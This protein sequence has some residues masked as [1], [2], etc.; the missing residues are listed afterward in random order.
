M[1]TSAGR[2]ESGKALEI[3][4]GVMRDVERRHERPTNDRHSELKQ[5]R[6]LLAVRAF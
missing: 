2:P 4:V 3:A 6:K 1:R 5:S